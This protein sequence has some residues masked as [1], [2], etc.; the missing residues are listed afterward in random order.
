MTLA[1]PKAEAKLSR[2]GVNDSM[3]GDWFAS[4]SFLN[5]VSAMTRIGDVIVRATN[6]A[7][8]VT[9][10]FPLLFIAGASDTTIA[11]NPKS[12]SG[13][14]KE[15]IRRAVLRSVANG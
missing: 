13:R 5:A 7:S 15:P 11:A 2:V 9:A 10:N 14:D 12:L 1:S 6:H 4:I 3:N 8:P